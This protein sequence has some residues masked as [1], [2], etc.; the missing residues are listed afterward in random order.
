MDRPTIW[1]I[2]SLII[3]TICDFLIIN[4]RD[5]SLILIGMSIGTII[6]WLFKDNKRRVKTKNG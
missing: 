2:C 6:T 3:V 4:R 5:C 1:F